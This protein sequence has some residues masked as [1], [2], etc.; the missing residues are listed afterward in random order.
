LSDELS[1]D[2]ILR[3]RLRIWQP[4]QG[5][6]F[7]VDPLLI[8]AFVRGASPG[9]LGRV[10]DLGTGSGIIAL[11]LALDDAAAKLVAVELQPRLAQLA[12]RN[13]VDNHLAD[14][15]EICELD[16]ADAEAMKALPGASFDWAVS[17][18]PFRALADGP[19]SP[20]GEE[21]IA[22][23]EV[24]LDLP[25]LC[26]QARRLLTP[27]GRFA[28]VYPSERLPALL[29]ALDAAGLR[30][31]GLRLVHDQST[32]PARRALV[33]AQKGARG[34]LVVDPPLFLRNSDGAY[35]DEAKQILG[36]P[37]VSTRGA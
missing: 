7:A 18:P 36:D 25:A 32:A 23:H 17:N 5:Y 31:I 35:T 19:P 27:H 14:R 21:A 16:I 28:V 8:A 1:C 24:R 33:V 13:A 4:R 10:V 9:G 37:W 3:G 2:E 20:D 15:V 26:G 29:A 11:A 22:K 34:G 30:P 12:R 6:R